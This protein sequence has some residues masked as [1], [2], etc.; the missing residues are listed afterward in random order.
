[1]FTRSFYPKQVIHL[2][3][4]NIST[5][6]FEDIDWEVMTF[7]DDPK[8]KPEK[9]VIYLDNNPLNCDCQ[10]LHFLYYFEQKF[11]DLVYEAVKVE[12]KD[13]KCAAPPELKNEPVTSLSSERVKCSISC[14]GI[15]HCLDYPGKQALVVDC[16]NK[17]LKFLPDTFL[18]VLKHFHL[19]NYSFE[20]D[21]KG[22]EFERTPSMKEFTQMNVTSVDLSSNQISEVTLD[23]FTMTLK[24]LK[25][26][27]NK[28]SHLDTEVTKFLEIN[29]LSLRNLSLYNNEWVCN[30]KNVNFMTLVRSNPVIFG[31]SNKYI[32][33][34][35]RHEFSTL[36]SFEDLCKK[37]QSLNLIISLGIIIFIAVIACSAAIYYKY[38]MEIKIWLYS[39]QWCMWLVTEDELDKDK[40][41]DAFVSYSYEDRDFVYEKIVTTLEEGPKSYKLC[42]HDRDW[43]AGT[44]FVYTNFQL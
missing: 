32:C 12:A 2:R 36:S 39:K 23:V 10:I 28:I 34:D 9:R 35:T 42:L 37:S 13:L 5:I 3:D 1:M 11:N 30:C 16:S 8:I 33:N 19:K 15:C 18:D 31:L 22:N 43:L 21:L 40:K 29:V 6:D 24:E 20:F 25:L 41:Y 7:L 14:G 17:N 4:N 27:D 44:F 38:E 26:N